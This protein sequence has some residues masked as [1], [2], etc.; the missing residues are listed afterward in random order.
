MFGDKSDTKKD[1][2][3][4]SLRLFYKLMGTFWTGDA[5]FA[6]ASRH[7]HPLPALR[8]LEITVLSI[9]C[10]CKHTQEFPVFLASGRDVFG[11]HPEDAPDQQDPAEKT[12][13]RRPGKAPEGHTE[14][15][16]HET[17]TEY[18]DPQ[19]ILPISS[20]HEIPKLISDP[21]KHRHPPFLL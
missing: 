13:H 4:S 19:L 12:Q 11:I 14:D 7:T 15:R 8:T 10:S 9:L 21:A 20:H 16:K 3:N 5:Y 6:A 18:G 17:C 2:K 1:V